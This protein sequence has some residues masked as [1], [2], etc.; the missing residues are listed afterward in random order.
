MSKFFVKDVIDEC[1]EFGTKFI[2]F[3]GDGEPLLHKDIWEILSYSTEN[4]TANVGLT[5][6]GS[7]LNEKNREKL[8]STNLDMIDI[9]LDAAT[10]ATFAV[11]KLVLILTKL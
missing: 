8:L 4:T 6:N 7:G 9:S 5:S 11:V 2:R 10:E 1:K 3:T